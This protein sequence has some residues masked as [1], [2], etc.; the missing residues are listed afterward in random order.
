M[1]K[2]EQVSRDMGITKGQIQAKL[3]AGR[4]CPVCA[5]TKALVHFPRDPAT[6][7]A[8]EPGE[9]IHANTWGP[10]PVRGFDNTKLYLFM[11][12]DATR[13]T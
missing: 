9:L 8:Q 2:L 5:T 11:T 3:K 12:N 7:R 1:L 13:F 4:F 6:R 10:Y